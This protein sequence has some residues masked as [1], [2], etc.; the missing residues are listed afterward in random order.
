MPEDGVLTDEIEQ[1]FYSAA[2]EALRNARKHA[3]AQHVSVTVNRDDGRARLE[4][5]DDGRGFTAEERERS[6]A[7]GH[8]GLSIF[9]ELADRMH[10]RLEIDSSPGR[11]THFVLEVPSP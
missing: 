8:V 10:G 3:S 5:V 6:R 1:L 7:E 4:V 11:G 2:G 9:E